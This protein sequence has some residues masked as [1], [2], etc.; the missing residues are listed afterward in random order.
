MWG[1]S[2]TIKS[3]MFAHPSIGTC[4]L[5]GIENHVC[6]MYTCAEDRIIKIWNTINFKPIGTIIC[7]T[8]RTSTFQSMTQSGRHLMV[9][10][11]DASIAIFSK[12]CIYI[13][14]FIFIKLSNF[15]LI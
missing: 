7:P 10:T 12:V 14:L 2:R 13:N 9:G 8:L 11:S 6:L 1:H 5:H 15:K 4:E 3:I